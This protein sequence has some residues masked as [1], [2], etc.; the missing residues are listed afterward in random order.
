MYITISSI[1]KSLG[2]YIEMTDLYIGIP[3]LFLFLTL[4]SIDATRGIALI[5]LTVG[6]FLMIPVTVSKKNRMYKVAILI[7]KYLFGIKE[8]IYM[9]GD[10]NEKRETTK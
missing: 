1:K 3:M 10:N 6:V 9:K 7:F 5:I 4:F 2:K 8:Y